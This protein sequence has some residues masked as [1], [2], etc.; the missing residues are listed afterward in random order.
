M[1]GLWISFQLKHLKTNVLMSDLT[2]IKM[3]TDSTS[4]TQ[5]YCLQKHQEQQNETGCP[6]AIHP[7]LASGNFQM[8]TD[9]RIK[10]VW[11]EERKAKNQIISC[12]SCSKSPTTDSCSRG[13]RM[14][15]P[16]AL[17]VLHQG[18]SA[19]QRETLQVGWDLPEAGAASRGA[20]P[21]GDF[22]VQPHPGLFPA[23]NF[24][25]CPPKGE[26]E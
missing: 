12:Q 1:Q 22:Q 17:N 2:T 24:L 9:G 11:E 8:N 14:R 7:A 10:K 19:R 21:I 13:R 16:D 20:F 15:F 6:R 18:S 3:I 5:L 25:L 4:R 26:K 23:G